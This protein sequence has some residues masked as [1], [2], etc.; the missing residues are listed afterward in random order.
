MPAC[1]LDA[2]A[3]LAMTFDSRLRPA[4][5]VDACRAA[6]RSL[7][8]VPGLLTADGTVDP[9][10]GA[11]ILRCVF[12]SLPEREAFVLSP[13]YD[14]IPAICGLPAATRR[15]I[16]LDGEAADAGEALR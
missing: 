16:R 7:D 10:T 11:V 9:T 6:R 15:V 12:A 8:T 2:P 5:V 1:L 13:A 3:T 4:A 14:R